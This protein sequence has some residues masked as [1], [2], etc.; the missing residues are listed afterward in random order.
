MNRRA[1]D[2]LAGGAYRLERLEVRVRRY[3]HAEGS[4]T[5]KHPPPPIAIA[6]AG[7]RVMRGVS[8]PLAVEV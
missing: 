8:A 5:S 6:G 7:V 2:R 3:R 4:G 1:M